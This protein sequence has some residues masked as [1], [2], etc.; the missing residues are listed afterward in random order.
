[1]DIAKRLRTKE[2]VMS[3]EEFIE[4]ADEIERLREQLEEISTKHE[5]LVFSTIGDLSLR[6]IEIERLQNDKKY[7]LTQV[8]MLRQSMDWCKSL[9]FGIEQRLMTND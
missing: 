3:Y 8:Q 6:D 7:L 9:V 5:R 1:M 4:A 2:Y